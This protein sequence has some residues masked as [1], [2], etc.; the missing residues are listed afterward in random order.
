[1]RNLMRRQIGLAVFVTA[2][3][4]GWL[5][6]ESLGQSAAPETARTNKPPAIENAQSAVRLVALQ[7]PNPFVVKP[8][9]MTATRIGRLTWR[10]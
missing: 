6:G 10:S 5:S 1:M 8:S 3:T 9:L 7:S 2:I 4:A